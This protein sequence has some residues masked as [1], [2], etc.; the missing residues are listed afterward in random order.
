VIDGRKS[1][2]EISNDPKI[3]AQMVFV[4]STDGTVKQFSGGEVPVDLLELV[5]KARK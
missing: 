3:P 5:L 1:P 2:P 4:F